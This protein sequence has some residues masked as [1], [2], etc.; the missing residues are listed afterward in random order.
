MTNPTTTT[1]NP[2]SDEDHAILASY[3]PIVDGIAALLGEHCEVVLHSLEFLE[4]SAIYVVNGHLTERKVGSPISQQALRSLQTMRTDSVSEPYFSRLQ[5]GVLMK[6]ITI[7][8]RN[9]KQLVIGLICISLN[10][11]VPV[12]QFVQ[13][14][15][16][17]QNSTGDNINFAN[18]VEDLVAQSIDRTIYDVQ[19]DRNVANHNKNRQIVMNLF[20]KGIFDIKDAINQ[21]ADKLAISRHT[22][23]LYIRQ[24]K[25]E[26]EE[27][28]E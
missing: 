21:V 22:V 9:R 3:F 27:G 25:Q 10:L 28:S 18:S 19:Q 7:A 4:Q 17:P 2:L 8:I 16:A 13:T 20:E 15:I 1:F 26:Q 14:L 24:M 23:Y 5:D 6:S 12:S 11:D